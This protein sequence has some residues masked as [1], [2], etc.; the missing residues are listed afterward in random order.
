M[1]RTPSNLNRPWRLAA[2]LLL[3]ALVLSWRTLSARE[4]ATTPTLAF[5][6]TIGN[7][8]GCT[9]TDVAIRI[10]DVSNLYG[11]DVLVNFDP[12]LLE[13]VELRDANDGISGNLLT[14]PLFT[15]RK[16][17]DN[18][19]GQVRYAATQ[20]NPTPPANGS[21]NLLVIRFRARAAGIAP[22]AFGYWQLAAPGAT[23]I[24][25]NVLGGAVVTAPPAA[26]VAF[27][28]SRLNATS[29]RL[30]WSATAGVHAFEVFRETAPYQPPGSAWRAETASTTH[31]DDTAA[32]GNPLENHYYKLTAVC[33]NGFASPAAGHVGA[34]DFEIVT[35]DP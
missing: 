2:V 26:P 33:E 34:F 31:T 35:P 28:I 14:P 22:L 3:L 27:A 5:N 21:G 1:T 7:I 15:P 23:P 19:T 13:V 11:A 4:L 9:T 10:N 32:L 16:E 20:L 24:P 17:F 30:S 6:P 29:A 18:T 25:S 12:A 8:S